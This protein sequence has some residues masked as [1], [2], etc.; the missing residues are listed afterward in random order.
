MSG[1][2]VHPLR[3]WRLREGLTLD[4]AAAGVDTVRSTWYDW[5]TGRRLPG[6]R[7]TYDRLYRFTKGEITAN[8]MIFPSGYPTIG[9]MSLP[10]GGGPAP[11]LDHANASVGDSNNVAAGAEHGRTDAPPQ[12]QAAA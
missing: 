5:E 2:T 4:A 6:D 12:L 11:L 7:E 1:E 9:Q 10:F 3:S 8:E